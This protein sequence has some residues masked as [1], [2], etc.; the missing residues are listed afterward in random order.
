MSL[1]ITNPQVEF[2]AMPLGLDEQKPRFS[3]ELQS[4]R[5]GAGQVSRRILVLDGCDVVWD[6]GDVT[7]AQQPS[8]RYEG[9]AL[10]A[11][12]RYD[13][14][15]C[16]T[17]DAG[18]TA[19]ADTWFETGLMEEAIDKAFPGAEF[20]GPDET[21]LMAKV[22]SVFRYHAKFRATQAD[23]KIRF[24]FGAN[25]PRLLDKNKNDYNIEGPNE[26]AYE[27]DLSQEPA[28]IDIYRIGYCP[29]DKADT[30]LATFS[31][32]S[33]DEP[34]KALISQANALDW[35]TIDFEVA[36]NAAY[37]YIDGVKCD[38]TKQRLAFTPPG[39][40]PGVP[41]FIEKPRQLNPAGSTDV[42]PYPM[43]S[44]FGYESAEGFE[45]AEL[46]IF[47]LRSPEALI[48]DAGADG[49]L[50]QGRKLIDA[51]HTSTPMLRRAFTVKPGLKKARLYAT[52][53]G[54]YTPYVNGTKVS[55]HWFEPG[56][57]QFDTHLLY[58][59]YDITDLLAEGPAAAGFLLSSGWWN[60]SQTFSPT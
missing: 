24:I 1:R 14:K 28:K 10:M 5:R 57:G 41:V 34:E 38:S 42:T 15:I 52:A 29:E 4:D 21:V 26:I 27:L 56:A 43:L 16:V 37:T 49:S 46:Q 32:V 7:E 13:V 39:A 22:K 44:E 11:R 6:S 51:T 9:A 25:D 48:F 20:I 12:T 54:I 19:S 30:P 31:A 47:N 50:V 2:A 58:Q 40:K 53:R 59:T 18:E 36:E 8:V 3:Y 33:F 23:T 55:D 60:E 35:H 17:D 45:L